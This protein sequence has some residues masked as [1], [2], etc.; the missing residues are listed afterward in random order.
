M[1]ILIVDSNEEELFRLRTTL[2]NYPGI[3]EIHLATDL[4]GAKCLLA[5]N[6]F[7]IA[8]LDVSWK[9]LSDLF[10]SMQN[11]PH[12]VL[13][14]GDS[15]CEKNQDHA[16]AHHWLARPICERSLLLSLLHVACRG[17][18]PACEVAE[19]AP[20]RKRPQRH[21][22]SYSSIIA[23]EARG[24]YTNVLCGSEELFDR[25]R[26]RQWEALLTGY[27]FTRLDRSTL[28][29]LDRVNTWTV[30]GKGARVSFI[31]SPLKIKIGDVA[32]QRLR[33]LIPPPHRTSNHELGVACQE[34]ARR[35]KSAS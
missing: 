32:L 7:E 5:E 28:I 26:L 22:L 20:E 21:R 19:P 29:R 17:N 34:P 3:R 35:W 15:L 9:D 31:R 8:F 24:N 4:Q 2:A 12:L 23:V 25:C 27:G 16:L 11:P 10:Q 14:G 13:M 1:R 6:E 33:S 30:E 18:T